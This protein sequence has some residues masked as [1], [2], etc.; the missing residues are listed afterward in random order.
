MNEGTYILNIEKQI[1]YAMME[2]Q[3]ERERL[4]GQLQKILLRRVVGAGQVNTAVPGLALSRWEKAT[5]LRNTFS[6]PVVGLAVQGS[7]CAIIGREEY[8]HDAGDCCIVGVDMPIVSYVTFA[9]P[10]KPFLS[11]AL[12]LD[13]QLIA[14]LAT[15]IQFSAS[16]GPCSTRGMSIFKA[17]RELLNAIL[18]LVEVLD[19]PKDIQ[20]M[21]PLIIREI[22]YRL[23]TGQQGAWLRTVC[24]VG[25]KTNQIAQAIT[26]L[27]KTY[28]ESLSIDELAVSVD[29]ARSTFH[30]HFKEVTNMSPLQFQKQLRMHE[31]Q[32]L[33]LIDRYDVGTAAHSVGYESPTQFI[34]EYKRQFG[35][36]PHRNVSK[37][38]ELQ[39]II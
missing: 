32:R 1:G 23:L 30:R 38:R 19:R 8:R 11:I 2:E 12:S 26:S 9:S 3:D 18:R 10:E 6:N 39:E 27:R 13:R 37:I 16:S 20:V 36:S 25:T 21:A 34:R 31:A 29:M 4:C 22:H 5:E 15:E 14:Q 33:M 7:K 24:T 35:E 17:E 28:K